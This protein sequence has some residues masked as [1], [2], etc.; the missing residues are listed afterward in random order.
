MRTVFPTITGLP[1]LRQ[2]KGLL[3]LG[4]DV[5]VYSFS[6]GI[7]TEK[8]LTDKTIAEHTKYIESGL[9]Q[10]LIFGALNSIRLLAS[11]PRAL[12]EAIRS[13]SGTTLRMIARLQELPNRKN[14]FD[15]I[16]CHFGLEGILGLFLKSWGRI[17]LVVSLNAHDLYRSPIRGRTIEQAYAV[18]FDRADRVIA[19]SD[20]TLARV[21]E[22]GCPPAKLEMLRVGIDLERFPYITRKSGNRVI[23]IITVG[24]L[25]E[26]K[27]YKYA[28]QA[29]HQLQQKYDLR[30]T[31]IGNGPLEEDLKELALRLGIQH[32]VEFTGALH[33]DEVSSRLQQ[34]DIF[35]L[36]S[37]THVTGLQETVGNALIE[38]QAT[39]LPCV[40][41]DIGGIPETI[42]DRVSGLLVGEKDSTA[43]AKS[44]AQLCV[45]RNK[46]QRMG[47]AGRK[48]VEE[49]FDVTKSSEQLA[50]IYRSVIEMS[51]DPGHSTRRAIK[52]GVS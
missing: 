44:I 4:H 37:V 32:I 9:T 25:S 5:T 27:G 15:V 1:R 14:G 39:G 40:A 52:D 19:N 38:A 18:L 33:I 10:R 16:H 45:D 51:E 46:R 20:A 28:L 41:S 31:V 43:I 49:R 26:E 24:R 13:R 12:R 7:G 3:A 34:A 6:R 21:L 22:I 23:E 11:N 8:Y 29:I 50:D 30:Y 47:A 48:H 42:I 35:L 17:P 2:F 36:P